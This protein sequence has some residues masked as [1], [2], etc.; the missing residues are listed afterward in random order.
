MAKKSRKVAARYS[1]LSRGKKKSQNKHSPQPRAALTPGA[2]A[3]AQAPV[4]ERSIF[5]TTQKPQPGS[6]QSVPGY[7][8]VRGDLKRI[9]MLAG[10]GVAILV[11]LTFILG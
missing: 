2:Q 1:E 8:Y 9:G 10:G 5:R 11:V 7:Q 3:V 4:R 6:A